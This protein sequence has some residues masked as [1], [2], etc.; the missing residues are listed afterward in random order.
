[1]EKYTPQI[2]WE[3]LQSPMAKSKDPLRDEELKQL[4][5]SITTGFF[6]HFWSLWL[7]AVITECIFN[8]CFCDDK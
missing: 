5:Q 3:E 1:M 4:M 6:F 2:S 7:G 8:L